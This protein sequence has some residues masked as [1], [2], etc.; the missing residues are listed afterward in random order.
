MVSVSEADSRV[1]RVDRRLVVE[2]EVRVGAMSRG[3]EDISL[4]VKQDRVDLRRARVNGEDRGP[5][6]WKLP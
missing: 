2:A 4:A 5:S 1:E 3:T 6:I